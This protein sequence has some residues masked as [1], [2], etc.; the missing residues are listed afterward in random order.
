MP[1]G[2]IPKHLRSSISDGALLAHPAANAPKKNK[3]EK[4]EWFHWRTT[5][6]QAPPLALDNRYILH[7]AYNTRRDVGPPPAAPPRVPQRPKMET[8]TYA[9]PLP[10][11]PSTTSAAPRPGFLD[12]Y[13]DGSAAVARRPA[14][15]PP[16]RQPKH[17][18]DGFVASKEM[19]W[20][21][22]SWTSTHA[23]P[24]SNKVT[25]LDPQ[26]PTWA[27]IPLPAPPP[28]SQLESNWATSMLPRRPG[29][30]AASLMASS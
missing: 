20:Y 23:L 7:C 2:E 25:G 28:R 16:P 3:L 13:F 14:V 11:R 24:I 6:Y 19:L 15:L 4:Y 26:G 30:L 8:R 29:E 22:S 17:A 5:G 1:A 21:R 10:S 27:G 9:L 18:G 12:N